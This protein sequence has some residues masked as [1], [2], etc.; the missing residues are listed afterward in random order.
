M[1]SIHFLVNK[2]FVDI[3]IPCI[4]E[5]A[6]KFPTSWT[7]K[8]R[9]EVYEKLICLR[10]EKEFNESQRNELRRLSERLKTM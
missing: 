6:D 4:L 8:L 3:I 5:A 9:M 7:I 1:K 10:E 2:E